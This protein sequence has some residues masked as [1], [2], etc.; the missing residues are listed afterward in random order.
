MITRCSNNYGPLQHLEKFIPKVITSALAGNKI[1]IYGDGGQIRDWLFV[2]D[3]CRA[4][5]AVLEKGRI[6]SVYNIGGDEEQTNLAVVE[7]IID[8]LGAESEFN[9]ICRRSFRS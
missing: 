9:Y 8:Y 3:H 7:Q 5:H 1:P 6:G 4:I 2:E